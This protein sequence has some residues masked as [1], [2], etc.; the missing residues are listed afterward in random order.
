LKIPKWAGGAVLAFLSVPVVAQTAANWTAESPQTNPP[1]RYGNAMAYDSTH[2]Q[3]VMF[4]GTGSGGL[5]QGLIPYL[6]DTWLW[7]GSNWTAATPQ[8]VP[9][10]RSNHA[11][12]YASGLNQLVMFGGVI[13]GNVGLAKDTWVWNGSNWINQN[14]SLG[15]SVR[16]GHTMA[17]DSAHNQVVMFGGNGPFQPGCSYL[18]DTWIWNGSEWTQATPQTS[19]P[20]RAGHGMAYDSARG[21]VVVFGG[22][23]ASGFGNQC[24]SQNLN[25]TWVW[26]GSNWTEE[27]PKT[28]PP[29][30]NS[31][32]MAFDAAHG[33]TVLFGGVGAGG[34]FDANND[35]WIWDGSNWTQESPQTSPSARTEYAMA[36]DSTHSQI[37]LFGGQLNTSGLPVAADTWI[38][39]GAPLQVGPTINAVVNGASFV[40]GGVV[41]GEIATLFGTNLTSS[42][43]I[44]LT[45]GLPLPETFLTD[46]LMVSAHAAALF[47]VDN[48]SGQQQINFQVPWEVASGPMANITIESNTA[49]S[50]SLA[51]PVLAAQP[52]I[53]NYTAGEDTFG[54]ILHANF[55]LANTANPAK[56][57][58]TVLIYCT[59]LGAVSSPPADGAAGNGQETTTTPTVTIGGTKAIVSFSGLAPTFVGLYQINSE[60]PAGLKAG[61]QAVVITLSG[62]SSN[63]VLLPIE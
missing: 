38:W 5:Q 16:Y 20:A 12:A 30:L 63:S 44:N 11:M 61:N 40:G 53:F 2:S 47:A 4:G 49:T 26:D 29:T 36:Y 54:A 25:D 13:N 50:A 58:E 17:Y 10:A 35:T 46:S 23:G 32:A 31:F 55:Q 7:N 6:N 9:T 14:L 34:V 60:V 3:T 51:V 1:A 15:P 48:V 45:S 33:Q 19:P 18:G 59:G 27:S 37:V 28:M 62:A 8:A 52:G 43:G 57:G 24:T 42:T 41:A 21:K 56:G 22:V 39:T